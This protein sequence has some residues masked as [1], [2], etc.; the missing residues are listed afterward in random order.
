MRLP[1]RDVGRLADQGAPRASARSALLRI[2]IGSSQSYLSA[3]NQHER[4]AA[5]HTRAGETLGLLGWLALTGAAAAAGAVASADAGTFYGQLARPDWAPPPWLFAPVWTVLY[6][7]MSIAAWLVWRARGW[8]GAPAALGVYAAQL[9]ANALWTWL[10]FGWHRGAWAFGEI[11]VLWL[12][13]V[14]TIAL[15]WRVRRLAAVL[16]LPYATWVT[17]ASALTYAI[18]ALNPQAL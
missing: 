10:F 6:V 8:R 7:L 11:L 5:R 16:L 12:L 17:F 1:A 13:I 4:S 14:A 18:W 3:M 9:A 15:F 2:A